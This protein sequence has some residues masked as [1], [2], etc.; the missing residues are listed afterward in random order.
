MKSTKKLSVIAVAALIISCAS[1]TK[2]EPADSKNESAPVSYSKNDL[3][4]IKWIEGKWKGMA[5]K[6]PFYEIYQ[7]TNDS[8]LMITSYEWNGKDSS[9]SSVDLLHW[10]TDA[11]YLGK[12]QNYK[13]TDITDTEIKMIPLKGSNDILWKMGSDSGWVAVLKGKKQTVTYEM[14][15]FDPFG[16]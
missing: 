2:N 9:K 4:K 12:E 11:Y 6:D 3:A 10:K 15:A 8:T 16:K 5:G 1:S 7:F 13:V 14:K